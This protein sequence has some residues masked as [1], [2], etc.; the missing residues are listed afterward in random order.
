MENRYQKLTEAIHTP[1]GLNDRVLFEAR[2]R[3]VEQ[4]GARRS[5]RQPLVRMAL[6]AVCALALLLGGFSLRPAP[7]VESGTSAGNAA[8]TDAETQVLTPT[9]GLTAYAAG[10]GEAYPVGEDGAIAFASGEGIANPG[11][12]DFTGCL[13]QLTGD[14]IAYVTMSVDRGGL[15]RYRIVDH[16]T[17][18]QI[19]QYRQDMVEG[20]LTTACISQTEDGV[21][22]VPEMSVL[23]DNAREEYDPEVRYGFWVPPGEMIS[24]GEDAD[25]RAEAWADIDIF[26]GASLYVTATFENGG[27]RTQVYRLHTGNLKVDWTEDYVLTVLPE[28]AEGDDPFVHS[29][30][31]VPE[32]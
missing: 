16:L 20:R 22:Y 4:A 28:L 13:F 2:R 27:E 32:N 15:Y 10:T 25:L 9:F 30:Y 5:W 1:A 24:L 8:P 18:E 21:W 6:C 17:D 29:I 3:T 23:E 12:G 19:E 14:D 26:D 7:A 31:A 11:E